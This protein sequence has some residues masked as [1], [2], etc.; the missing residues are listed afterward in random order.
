MH[1]KS[2]ATDFNPE[3]DP[4]TMAANSYGNAKPKAQNY[5]TPA[6]GDAKRGCREGH[7]WSMQSSDAHQYDAGRPVR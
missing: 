3:K 2:G 5:Q 6:V 1:S 7:T 4:A